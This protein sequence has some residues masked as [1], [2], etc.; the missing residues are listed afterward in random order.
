[1]FKR[2]VLIL[3]F[4]L[5][6][7]SACSYNFFYS[8]LDNIIPLY[9][10]NMVELEHLDERV[11]QE[12]IAI[13]I[14]HQQQQLPL[15]INW[16][17]DAKKLLPVDIKQPVM[18]DQVLNRIQQLSEIWQLLR[19]KLYIDLARLLPLLNADQVDELFNSLEDN[20]QEYIKQQVSL[21]DEDRQQLYQQRLTD[22]FEDWLGYLNEKQRQLLLQSSTGFQ[23]LAA[24]RLKARLEWQRETRQILI[25]EEID[26]QS[27]LLVL[28][29]RLSLKH[30]QMYQ[31]MSQVNR[32][33]LS[34]LITKILTTLESKQYKNI[35]DKLDHYIGMMTDFRNHQWKKI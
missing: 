17:E 34:L 13:L 23:S 19:S 21:S 30:D 15:Y 22:Q 26:H 33:K 18:N 20:N 32:E 5:L 9:I 4:S 10:N 27:A 3:S 14:W 28:F 8:Q 11:D 24:L 25:T 12:T 16:L 1:M 29:K 35:T 2:H 6:L 7:L 31:P